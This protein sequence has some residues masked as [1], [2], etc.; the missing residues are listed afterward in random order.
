MQHTCELVHSTITAVSLFYNLLG[1]YCHM[2]GE[3]GG[4]QGDEAAD[5]P[6]DGQA[7]Q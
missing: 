4:W 2:P 3:D 5:R 1:L 6:D 7:L